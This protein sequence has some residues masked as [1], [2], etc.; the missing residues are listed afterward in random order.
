[1]PI[2]HVHNL[3]HP[4]D[5]AKK[6][7]IRVS[8]RPSDPFRNLV[9]SDWAREHWYATTTERDH[10]LAQMSEHYVYFRPGDRP[11]LEFETMDRP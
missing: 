7:G 2:C 9:G 8:L 5:T 4:V 6:F 11:T 3:A 10:A 1:M